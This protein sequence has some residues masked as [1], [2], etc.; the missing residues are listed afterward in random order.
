[1]DVGYGHNYFG[2]HPHGGVISVREPRFNQVSLPQDNATDVSVEQWITYEVYHAAGAPITELDYKS[3]IIEVSEDG[4]TTYNDVGQI[5]YHL[6]IRDKGNHIV[7][8]K[9][10]RDGNWP[11]SSEIRIR[12]QAI[13]EYGN[14]STKEF[15]LRWD[16]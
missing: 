3:L 7:W 9:I 5:P 15:P 16:V 4:G 6:T 13:D 1:M 14:V 12:H 8:V 2:Q 10:L 11:E